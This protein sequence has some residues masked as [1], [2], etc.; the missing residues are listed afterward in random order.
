MERHRLAHSQYHKNDSTIKKT[1]HLFSQVR[2]RNSQFIENITYF[3]FFFHCCHFFF[4]TKAK[5]IR[6]FFCAIKA[7]KRTRA[8]WLFPDRLTSTRPALHTSAFGTLF[9][10]IARAGPDGSYDNFTN[11]RDKDDHMRALTES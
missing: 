6:L 9:Y 2:T 5:N 3:L 4:A 11:P 1:S 7:Y 8:G 10:G